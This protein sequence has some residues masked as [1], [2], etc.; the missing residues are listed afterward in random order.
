MSKRGMSRHLRALAITI[1]TLGGA[2]APQEELTE[3]PPPAFA[4]QAEVRKPTHHSVSIACGPAPGSTIAEWWNISAGIVRVR[5]NSHRTYDRHPD[6]ESRPAIYTE[7][8]VTVLDVF[9]LHPRGTGVGGTMTITHPGGT[10]ERPDAY[11]VSTANGF[12]P[13][14]VG[15]EW[16]LFLHWD[17]DPNEF[18]IFSLQYGAFEIVQ[19]RIAPIADSRFGAL[20]SGKDAAAFA[21]ALRTLQ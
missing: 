12:R 20:W 15:T 19:G 16:M 13:P 18:W 1:L 3:V 10:L 2:P 17:S 5:I 6:P 7:L 9:K 14:P 21:D 8:D 4:V 11:Y